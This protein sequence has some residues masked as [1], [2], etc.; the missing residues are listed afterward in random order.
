MAAHVDLAR[1]IEE[2]V[3]LWPSLHVETTYHSG[4]L[5]RW[6][7]DPID[8]AAQNAGEKVPVT[9]VN[10]KGRPLDDTL[11]VIPLA[12]LEAFLGTP[13]TREEMLEVWGLEDVDEGE[14]L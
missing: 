10:Q 4:D 8:G 13:A 3:G 1:R 14:P 6:L 5:P 11:V 12:Q 9:V 2:G 7:A